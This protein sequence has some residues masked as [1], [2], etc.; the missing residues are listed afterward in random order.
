MDWLQHGTPQQPEDHDVLSPMVLDESFVQEDTAMQDAEQQPRHADHLVMHTQHAASSAMG[1]AQVQEA[2]V[3]MPLVTPNPTATATATALPTF[4]ASA[5]QRAGFESK[6]EA[7]AW[8]AAEGYA[9]AKT[10]LSSLGVSHGSDVALL[11]VH[12][13]AGL[14]GIKPITRNKMCLILDR[15]VSDADRLQMVFEQHQAWLEE[16]LGMEAAG[17]YLTVEL[18]LYVRDYVY[19]VAIYTCLCCSSHGIRR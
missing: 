2:N 14:A 17:E 13:V 18:E 12:Q 15:L 8:L 6:A 16:N 10:A 5:L 7:I 11:N 19:I 4:T 9:K 3:L 1:D